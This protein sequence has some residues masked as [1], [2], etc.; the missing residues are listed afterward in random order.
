[1]IKTL[2]IHFDDCDTIEIDWD[3]VIS[4]GMTDVNKAYQYIKKALRTIYSI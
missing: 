1:M 2:K 4:L 3:N